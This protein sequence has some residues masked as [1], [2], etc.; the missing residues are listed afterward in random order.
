MRAICVSIGQGETLS[1]WLAFLHCRFMLVQMN[2]GSHMMYL[3]LMLHFAFVIALTLKVRAQEVYYIT[4]AFTEC[5]WAASASDTLSPDSAKQSANPTTMLVPES[6]EVGSSNL[7]YP[8]SSL[9]PADSENQEGLQSPGVV[10]YSMPPCAVC[11]CQTCTTTSVFTTMLPD[12]GPNGPSERPYTI[13]ET[14]VGMSSLPYFPTPT[15][16]PYGFTIAFETCTECGAQ[17]ITGIVVTPKTGRS[18][19][20]DIAVATGG[21][22]IRPSDAPPPLKS[23]A[24]LPPDISKAIAS[25]RT[26][27][28]SSHPPNSGSDSLPDTS[29]ATDGLRSQPSAAPPSKSDQDLPTGVIKTSG[30]IGAVETTFSTRTEHTARKTKVGGQCSEV[31]DGEI[32]TSEPSARP[33]SYIQVS[34][35]ETSWQDCLLL[36]YVITLAFWVVFLF[37]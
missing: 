24:D 8:P 25:L 32:R 14:Y 36:Y 12:F 26:Q 27:P 2:V 19:G 21:L 6:D 1:S 15:P 10:A 16:I 37:Q 22:E 17:P 28:S 5:F 4:S 20:Q 7:A 35:A 11:D 13:T 3:N 18:W 33:N 31:W 23:A 29:E 9:S 30:I 34:A